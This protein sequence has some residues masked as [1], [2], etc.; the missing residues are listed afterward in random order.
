MQQGQ[1]REHLLLLVMVF[2]VAALWVGGPAGAVATGAAGEEGS[3]GRSGTTVAYKEV[4]DATI[5]R[6]RKLHYTESAQV[7]LVLVPASVTDR[8][9]RVIRGLAEDDFRIY[10]DGALQE[11]RYFAAEAREPVSIA[12]VLDVSGSMRQ[13]DK[14]VHAKEGI[15]HIVDGLR[16]GDQFALI[17]FADRQVAWVTEFTHDR[18]RFLRRLD[19]QEGYGQTALNDAVAA[20]PGLVDDTI[21]GRKA[22]VLITDGVDNF[23]RMAP[24]E[25]VELA[26]RVNVPI[27]SIG[28]LS[29]APQLLRGDEPVLS[30]ENME[31]FSDETGG[32]LFLVHD[33]DELKEAVLLLDNELRY[34]YVLGYSLHPSRAD[35]EFHEIR[36]EVDSRRAT[37]RARNGYIASR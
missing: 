31:R 35:G 33:P 28:F 30:V 17:C 29:V 36:V 37:V 6:L 15:R 2:A 26:R 19:V 1:A 25:A 11:I 5:E 7:R 16:P 9:G 13:L 24:Q 18:E 10:D 34:Q 20:T 23:S 22:I 21:Q 3:E 14:L 4:D 32:R 12:F 27:Y 8:Q